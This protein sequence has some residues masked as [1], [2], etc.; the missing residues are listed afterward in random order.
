MRSLDGSKIPTT[1]GEFRLLKKGIP[2]L[3][4]VCCCIA[5]S[6]TFLAKAI[7]TSPPKTSSAGNS[8]AS[9]HLQSDEDKLLEAQLSTVREY[10]EKLLQTVYWSLGGVF[11]LV[12]LVG[13]INWF[14]N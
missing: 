11:L 13:G 6:L 12:V 2:E 4:L 5:V 9:A 7:T 14:T 3:I 8:P 10:D 1:R